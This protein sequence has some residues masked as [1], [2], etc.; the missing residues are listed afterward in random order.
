VESDELGVYLIY[1]LLHPHYIIYIRKD[2]YSGR[3]IYNHKKIYN[4]E[5][6]I[7][8]KNILTSIRTF[9]KS[10]QYSKYIDYRLWYVCNKPAPYLYQPL[11]YIQ[12]YKKYFA[13][14]YEIL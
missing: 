4:L 13:F 14:N 6:N 1:L 11:D 12:D 2:F 10:L 7:C 9:I 8:F 5:I 3:I